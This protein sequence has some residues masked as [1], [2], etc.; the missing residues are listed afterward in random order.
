[1]R[2]LLA[3][4][5]FTGLAQAQVGTV[6]ELSGSAQIKRG[7][8]VLPIALNTPVEQNDRIETR[9]GKLKITFADRTVVQV[10]ESS[11][12][13]IDEFVYSGN[14][15]GKLSATAALG[16]VR[17]VSG[18]IAAKD[19][20]KVNLKT[21]TA[22]IA[23][24][25][26]DFVMSV[27]ETGSSMIILMPTC[28]SNPAQGKQCGSGSIDVHSGGNTVSMNRPFQ[29]TM[30]ERA[31]DAPSPP[32][33]VDLGATGVSNNLHVAPPR[34]QSGQNIV[35]AARDAAGK[36]GDLARRDAEKAAAEAQATETKS[37][38][39]ETRTVNAEATANRVAGISR[40]ENPYLFKLWADRAQTRQ[41]GWLYEV[42]SPSAVNYS[43][44]IQPRDTQTLISVTQDGITNNYNFSH[45]RPQGT[46]TVI[47]NNR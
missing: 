23:V 25:G 22:T 31:G 32:V 40:T 42:L 15:D 36:T 47:Q 21:P 45:A 9:G 4:A 2:A 18:S 41:I 24:R 10:T 13:V 14:G 6:T 20:K 8:T 30:V 44:I 29:A 43:N 3:L 16:T 33:T 28:E 17:Y 5:L 26:T 35:A 46:I 27:N 1:M 7:G 34:T 38:D 19:P 37:S 11:A 39:S 12:L